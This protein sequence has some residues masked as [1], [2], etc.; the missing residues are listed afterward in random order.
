MKPFLML[1]VIG[2]SAISYSLSAQSAFDKMTNEKMSKIILREGEDVEG[3]LGRWQFKYH[4][5]QL[6]VITDE[7]AN[8]MRVMTPVIEEKDLE[9]DQYK[10]MLEAN[11]DRALDAKYSIYQDVVWSVFTH[12]LGELTVE[13]FKDALNQ[14]SRLA[15]NFGGSYTS[16]DWAFSSGQN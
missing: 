10:T 2:L 4:E 5:F 13:Q 16:T 3:S 6:F 1:L 8:R 7:N 9:K 15:E 12:P 14:V 11:F